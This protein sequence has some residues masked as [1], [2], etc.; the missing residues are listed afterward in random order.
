MLEDVMKAMKEV[1]KEGAVKVKYEGEFY[2]IGHCFRI[3]GTKVVGNMAEI[4]TAVGKLEY[5]LVTIK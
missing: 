3:Q 5:K 4:V 1:V 2:G